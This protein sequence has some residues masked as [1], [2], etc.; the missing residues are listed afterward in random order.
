[1]YYVEYIHQKGFLNMD[2][3]IQLAAVILA[4]VYQGASDTLPILGD[5][6]KQHEGFAELADEL[7]GLLFAV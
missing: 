7:E 4:D 6:K 3:F 2:F 1:M 5:L